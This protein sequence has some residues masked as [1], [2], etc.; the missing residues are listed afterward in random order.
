MEYPKINSLYKRELA[1]SKK[2]PKIIE[3]QYAC[4]EFGSFKHWRV[5][6]KIDGMN[7]RVY[8]HNDVVTIMGRGPD[9]VIPDKLLAF[10]DDTW[11]NNI[12]AY[13]VFNKGPIQLFG[14]GFG[15]GIQH[16]GIYRPDQAFI[17]FD[18]L[19]NG[20]WGTR[21]EVDE[22]ARALG[23]ERPHD[24]GLMTE[25]EILAFVKSKPK[26]KYGHQVYE[27]EGVMCRSEPIM[28]FNAH[29]HPIQWKLKVKDF[30]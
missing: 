18:T 21:E 11:K 19:M 25:E 17:L 10:F 4:P 14:E 23:L 1:T 13:T 30:A 15:A 7:L 24:F 5:E 8:I 20:R 16:G 6:E 9:S 28:R 26:G 2:K 29:G 27:I 3:G 22:V 12:E